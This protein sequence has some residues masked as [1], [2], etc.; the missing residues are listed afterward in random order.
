L[1]E[2]RRLLASVTSSAFTFETAQKNTFTFDADVSAT[3]SQADINVNNLSSSTESVLNPTNLLLNNP[4]GNQWELT[5]PGYEFGAVPDGNYETIIE[6]QGVTGL[7]DDHVLPFFFVNGDFT[8]D[9]S[10]NLDDFTALAAGFGMPGTFSNGDGSYNGNVDLDDFTLMSAKFGMTLSP[11]PTEP[12]TLSVDPGAAPNLNAVV[13]LHWVAPAGTSTPP[14][15]GYRVFRSLDGTDFG[16]THYAQIDNPNATTFTDTNVV[17]GTKYW[18]RVRAFSA[19]GNSHTTNKLDAITTLRA[20]TN[21]SVTQ[22]ETA[23]F[24]LEWTNNSQVD[25]TVAIRRSTDP[26]LPLNQWAVVQTVSASLT[27]FTDTIPESGV[28][29]LYFVEA[30]N[31]AQ[32]SAPSNIVS[33]PP[34]APSG[35]IAAFSQSPNRIDVDWADNSE[36]GVLYNVYRSTEPDFVPDPDTNLV[37][38]ALS[39][40]MFSDQ[41]I[42]MNTEY[43]YQV[44]ATLP[45]SQFGPETLGGE[46][47]ASESAEAFSSNAA[48]PFLNPI[49]IVDNDSVQLTWKD[50]VNSESAYL[51][52][53]EVSTNTFETI[54]TLPVGRTHYFVENL[55]SET[56]YRFRV[57]AVLESTTVFSSVNEAETAS[58]EDRRELVIVVLGHLQTLNRLP[59]TVNPESAGLSQLA[60]RLRNDEGFRVRRV[61]EWHRDQ[62]SI[63]HN[64][65]GEVLD[66]ALDELSG[67]NG[68]LDVA[69]I[70]YS[71]GADVARQ[72]SQHIAQA[73]G[74]TDLWRV[75]Y[76]AYV[77]GI[78]R[79]EFDPNPFTSP[80]TQKPNISPSQDHQ[81]QNFH[82]T[83]SWNLFTN[84]VRGVPVPSSLNEPIAV[85]H[86]TIDD[87]VSSVHEEIIRKV[88]E[89]FGI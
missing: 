18:Y 76:T 78:Q 41:T 71:H 15:L 23:Q 82:N 27:Q 45:I 50:R 8:H 85:G 5:F 73:R 67:N 43:H 22:V 87:Q 69:V 20:P 28:R 33:T 63:N 9:R 25:E 58:V 79:G 37:A 24:Q 84:A 86:N 46:S 34:S 40:S 49:E 19:A 54:A 70:G 72:L 42:A 61:S 59:P 89:R 48:A 65:T 52:Q 36:S 38:S 53:Q 30:S 31:P 16:T 44:T 7:N 83:A 10:V 35:I 26:A 21:L 4:S 66:C 60:F 39:S 74:F 12:N 75:R 29:W 13:N 77:D 2:P 88:N 68:I 17:E 32:T 47:F 57:G 62:P 64:G 6:K 14:R 80:V 11:P 55:S 1:L 81:H 3:F 51:V 56:L